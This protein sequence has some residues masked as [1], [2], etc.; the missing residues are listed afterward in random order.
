MPARGTGT[1]TYNDSPGFL[2]PLGEGRRL[3]C[4]GEVQAIDTWF[5]EVAP[6]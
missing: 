2:P 4:L 3:I 5:R 6:A 1:M